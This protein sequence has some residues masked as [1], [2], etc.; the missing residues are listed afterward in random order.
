M[1]YYVTGPLGAGKSLYAVRKIAKALMEGKAVVTNVE[2][3]PDW[4]E[5]LAGHNPYAR[6]N[7]NTRANYALELRTRFHYEHDL[8]KLT[9]VKIRGRGENRALLVLDEVH[10]D[11]NNRDFKEAKNNEFLRWLTLTRKYGY[12]VFL[13]SQHKDN[14]DAAARRIATAEIQLINFKQ[15]TRVPVVGTPLLPI[16][17]FRAIC[18]LND[19]SMGSG[20]RLWREIFWLSWHRKLYGTHQLF[21][22]ELNDPEAIWLPRSIDEVRLSLVPG[23]LAPDAPVGHGA[24]PASEPLSRDGSK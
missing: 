22:E 4:A 18:K 15:I 6:F 13:I 19:E 21:G 7:K 11:L 9:K 5:V 12:E 17:V 8:E 1:I 23:G 20:K 2:L 24:R 3:R 10:N 16:P 14:T